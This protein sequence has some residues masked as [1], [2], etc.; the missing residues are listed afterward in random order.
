MSREVSA[1]VCRELG[2]E[3][4]T[5]DACGVPVPYSIL[6]EPEAHLQIVPG[7]L[8]ADASSVEFTVTSPADY[9]SALFQVVLPIQPCV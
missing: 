5:F 9:R 7:S 2:G 4:F 8:S 6:G 1:V 3:E